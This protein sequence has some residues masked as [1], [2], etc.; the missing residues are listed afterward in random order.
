M[1]RTELLKVK[2]A[3]V[4]NKY[5]DTSLAK[6]ASQWGW[7]RLS[8]ELGIRKPSD[9]RIKKGY[10][11]KDYNQNTIYHKKMQLRKVQVMNDRGFTSK[12]IRDYKRK[13]YKSI[14]DNTKTIKFNDN[15]YKVFWPNDRD[16][17]HEVW[18][19]WSRKTKYTKGKRGYMPKPM[20]EL[21]YAINDKYNKVVNNKTGKKETNIHRRN[22]RYGFGVLNFIYVEDKEPN[23][24]RKIIEPDDR[25]IREYVY[26]TR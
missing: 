2:Y 1:N 17:R 3:L 21:G 20:R 12:A 19:E 11:I 24:A 8:M 22:S 13:S 6:K 16:N 15:S 7:E 10:D 9:K 26:N 23:E 25:E 4:K 18:K 5:Q 14:N